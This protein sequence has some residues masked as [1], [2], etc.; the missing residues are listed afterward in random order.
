MILNNKFMYTQVVEE[1]KG[2]ETTVVMEVSTLSIFYDKCNSDFHYKDYNDDGNGSG[3]GNNNSYS[4]GGGGG[5]ESQTHVNIV[6][7]KH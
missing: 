2:T 4:G 3:R 7:S 1:V 5:G 6:S